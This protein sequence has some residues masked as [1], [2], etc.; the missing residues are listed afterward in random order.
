MTIAE[1][2]DWLKDYIADPKFDYYYTGRIDGTK[3]RALGVYAH[4][5][6]TRP[7]YAIGQASSY[8]I[9]GIKL[10]IHWNDNPKESQEASMALFSALSRVDGVE[11]AVGTGQD[12]R[13]INYIQYVDLQCNEPIDVGCDAN[14]I[15]E[16]VINLN[17]F[18]RR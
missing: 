4:S 7:V 11:H 3:Q 5:Y 8:E 2:R 16:Y 9:N 6:S 18:S 10:L 1:V 13:V 15:C 12:R 17:I 14:D